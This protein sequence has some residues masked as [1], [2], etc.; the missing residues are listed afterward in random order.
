MK[1]GVEFQWHDAGEVWL[2]AGGKPEFPKLSARPGIYAFRFI[3]EEETTVYIGEA[4][5]LQRRVA[6]YR[7]P[8]PTQ[9]TNIRLSERMRAHLAGKGRVTVQSI[10]S[11]RIELDSSYGE[12]GE[13][14]G[15]S[16]PHA[17][18]EPDMSLSIHPAPIIRPLVPDPSGRT[19]VGC[20]V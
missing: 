14:R 17:L 5:D 8:G 4:E 1:V 19:A 12:L 15:A 10:V 11:A 13:S 3:G 7:N 6:H 2:D 16:Q 20:G 18:A 9:R